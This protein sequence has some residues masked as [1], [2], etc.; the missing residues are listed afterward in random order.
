MSV[1]P[2][3]ALVV[4]V[5]MLLAVACGPEATATESP[6]SSTPLQVRTT[7]PEAG[8]TDP[9]TE[10]ESESPTPGV[11]PVTAVLAAEPTMLLVGETAEVAFS[12]IDVEDLYAV[13]VHLR[14]DPEMLTVV[15]AGEE[16]GTVR[17]VDGDL[18]QVGFTV[19]NAVDNLGGTVD[20]AVTQMPPTKAASGSGELLRFAVRAE[21]PG[22]TTLQVESVILA[23]TKGEAIPIYV[24]ATQATLSIR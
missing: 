21:T 14:F 9:E 6:P 7:P 12:A 2:K 16:A 15:N 10:K 5:A 1:A 20:Y 18:L 23:S 22:V 17:V 8:M 11:A 24:D 13:E 3:F 4:I 19:V